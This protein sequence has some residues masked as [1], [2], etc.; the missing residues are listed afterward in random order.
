[1]KSPVDSLNSLRE[2]QGRLEAQIVR[3]AE[4]V[5]LGRLKIALLGLLS[6]WAV[7]SLTRGIWVLL[8]APSVSLP[9]ATV[10]NPPIMV[11]VSSGALEV[12]ID[13]MLNLGLFGDGIET[14][15]LPELDDSA[16]SNPRDG[17]EAG[18]RETQLNIVLTGIVASTADGLGSAMIERSGVQELYGVGDSIAGLEQVKLAK[19][20]AQQVVLDNR[21]TYELLKLFDD[22]AQPSVVQAASQ[23]S[24]AAA[25]S[26]QGRSLSP[27][28]VTE[29]EPSDRLIAGATARQVAAYRDQLYSDP[30]SLAALVD[31]TAVREGNALRGYRISPGADPKLF[32]SLGLRAG[33]IITSVNGYALNEPANA[34]K[35]YQMMRDVTQ[36]TIELERDGASL[37][38]AVDLDQ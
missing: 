15:G 19:V 8:P 33:D 5:Q 28:V 26:N 27:S 12:N 2:L 3:L 24:N 14:S 29:K 6:V 34:A 25:S 23:S 16:A 38:V 7:F 37:S 13:S 31:V 4:P 11:S 21:G 32:T 30:Q 36:A 20:M 9:A 22:S 10:I 18:A 17:I 1:M 35:L